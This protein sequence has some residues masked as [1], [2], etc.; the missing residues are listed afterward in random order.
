MKKR[1]LII[2]LDCAAPALVFDRNWELPNLKKLINNGI[3]G[4]LRSC[5][6]PITIPAWLVMATGRDPGELGLYGFR[7]RRGYEYSKM[8]IANSTAIKEKAVWDYLGEQNQQSILVGVPPSYPPKPV[9]GKLI[10]CFITPSNESAY[11]Y[12]EELR[13]ELEERFGPFRFDV[14]FRTED[15]SQVLSEIYKMTESHF[16]AIEYLIE[17]QDWSL[18]WLVEIGVDRMHHAFWKFMDKEH[19]LYQP[20]SPFETAIQDYYQFLDE[21]IGR[22][23]NKV[24]QRTSVLVVS[25]HGAKRMKGAFCVNDWLIEQ[26]DLVVIEPPQKG[27]S[28][29]NL[30]IDWSKT[31]AWGWGGYYARIFLNVEGRE[32]QGIIKPDDYETARDELAERLKAIRGPNGEEWKTVVIRPQEYYPEH[33]G[34]YPDLMVYFD[35]LYW[36]SAGTL[37]YGKLYLQ[38]N[39]TGPDDAVHDYDGIYILYDPEVSGG[40]EKEANILDIAPTILKLLSGPEVPGLKGRSLV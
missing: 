1:L 14:T 26:G 31:R 16:Q 5:D 37:G 2:G 17:D 28:I 10:S 24:D 36:R 23:L 40:Q 27:Q 25:D 38:E 18:F 34:D 35:D 7:H 6:P 8:W 4:K 32:A 29:D 21:K 15:R 13:Q 3:S 9:R 11:T 30:K 22:L 33:N 12:P 39:D 19:H 20:G